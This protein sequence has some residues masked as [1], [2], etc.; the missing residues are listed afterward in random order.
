MITVQCSLIFSHTHYFG[1]PNSKTPMQR[2]QSSYFYYQ[3]TI[4]SVT[5][6][7]T[8]LAKAKEI[9][10]VLKCSSADDYKYLEFYK[11]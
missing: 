5:I 10:I 6:L 7:N 11:Y 4:N 8:Y 1:V 2:N 3:L 9:K